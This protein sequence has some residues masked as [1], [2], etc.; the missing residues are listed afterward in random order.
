VYIQVNF[1]LLWAICIHSSQ[2]SHENVYSGYLPKMMLRKK[3][4]T[5]KPQKQSGSEW[6]SCG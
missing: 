2:K 3:N 1:S 4:K 5:K 6:T